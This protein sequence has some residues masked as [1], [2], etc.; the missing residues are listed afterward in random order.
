MRVLRSVRR[1][2]TAVGVP[3]SA[4]RTALA[5]H[6]VDLDATV[7]F[8]PWAAY[9]ELWTV[10]EAYCS[11]DA[12][13]LRV[14]A[15][16]P[17]GARDAIDYAMRTANTGRDVAAL[18]MRLAPTVN[19]GAVSAV[20][21]HPQGVC[22]SSR[23]LTGLTGTPGMSDFTLARMLGIIRIVF[24]DDVVPVAVHATRDSPDSPRR[25]QDFFR[26]EIVFE[27]SFNALILPGD[28]LSR[29]LPHADE[30]LHRVLLSHPQL[31]P[32]TTGGV[33]LSE[34]VARAAAELLDS[35]R[36][37][38]QTAIARRIGLSP[39]TLRRSLEVD[40]ASFASVLDDVRRVRAQRALIA[41]HRLADV[42]ESLGYES[43]STFVRAFRRWTGET[44]AAWRA[45]RASEDDAPDRPRP[46]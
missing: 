25:H 30:R 12:L 29:R 24:E 42:A 11:D 38:S 18:A 37:P 8:A 5:R 21:R 23:F 16:V 1:A 19:G 36:A 32:R 39:R 10:A 4:L 45:R 20:E 9:R 27:S 14:A 46:T 33:P 15:A 22:V 44:P 17:F 43:A 7:V 13:G 40:G 35:G 2:M 34:R 41:G 3:D 31:S 6:H 28:V 26:C